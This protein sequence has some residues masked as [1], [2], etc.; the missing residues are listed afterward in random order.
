M[1]LH[2]VFHVSLLEHA[3]GDPLHG[4][5]SSPPPAVIVDGEEEWEVERILDSR[6]YYRRLQC[7]V[8]WKGYDAPSWQPAENMEHAGGAVRDFHRLYPDRPRP[9]ALAGARALGWGYCHGGIMTGH[10]AALSVDRTRHLGPATPPGCGRGRIRS[11][12]MRLGQKEMAP[13]VVETLQG[14][15]RA[16]M[17]K[18]LRERLRVRQG[19]GG[20]DSKLEGC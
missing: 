9:F 7:F 10:S 12:E 15:L 18:T 11:G 6:L 20:L 14:R 16:K 3:A 2:P 1:R 8:K 19:I 4:Q 17:V 5:Q 13:R